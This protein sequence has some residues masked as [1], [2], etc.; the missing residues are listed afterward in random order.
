MDSNETKKTRFRVRPT[1]KKELCA[2]YGISYP[3]FRSW[4]NKNDELFEQLTD[5]G[6]DVY[7]KILTS[8]Q[9][10]LIYTHLGRP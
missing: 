4:I 8:K 7:S 10:I 5:I 9:V 2:K 6:Y 3:T 1:S